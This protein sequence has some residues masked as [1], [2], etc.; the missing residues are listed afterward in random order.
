MKIL[1]AGEI[2]IDQVMAGFASW[3]KPG[4]ESFASSFTREVGGGAPNTAAGLARLFAGSESKSSVAGIIGK[5]DGDFVRRRLAGLGVDISALREHPT[6]PTGTT[7]AVS[8]PE[9][10]A[11]FTYRGA[12]KAF[13]T[14]LEHLPAADHLHL[15]APSSVAAI[16]ALRSRSGTISIDS[17]WDPAWLRDRRVLE[18]LGN[19]GI[20]FPNEKEAACVTGESDPEKM[21]R[22]FEALDIT[23]VLKL[24]AQGS[25]ALDKGRFICMPAP[26]V[27]PVDTTGAGDNFN[28]GFLYA[29]LR[30]EPIERCLGLGNFCGALSTEAM[31]GIAGFPTPEQISKWHSK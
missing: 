21:L 6:E 9:D 11:F 14:T 15:A 10:R 12:N 2:Y 18:A 7:V 4:E 22:A 30:R 24:G 19:L 29:W 27:T 20:F 28:A 3:P 23:A 8:S 26:Q 17:G 25:A 31:G 16:Q 1:S 5:S 13:E